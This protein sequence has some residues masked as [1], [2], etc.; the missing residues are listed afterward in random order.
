LR[1]YTCA[2]YV[3]LVTLLVK[4]Q[5]KFL[6]N[7]FAVVFVVKRNLAYRFGSS[8]QHLDN[9]KL[10]YFVFLFIALPFCCFGAMFF[11][12]RYKN[13]RNIVALLVC[14]RNFITVFF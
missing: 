4:Q 11:K 2:F 10:F 12:Y 14:I 7:C 8:K 5:V 1:Y 3:L 13:A 9:L 6:V